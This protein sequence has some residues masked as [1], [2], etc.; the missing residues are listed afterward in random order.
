MNPPTLPSV[1]LP[2][3][4]GATPLPQMG[5]IRVQGEDAAKF[6]H[7][8]LTQDFAL[9]GLSEARLAAFCSAKGRML[10]SF[11]GFKLA[12]DDLLLVCSRDL[13]PATLKRLSMFVL[14]AKA[15]L[16]D[17]SAE[18]QVWGLSG[19]AAPAGA[20]PWSKSG[21]PGAA[22]TI[23]LYPSQG[24][25]RALWVAPAG[26]PPPAGDALPEAHWAWLDVM[27]GVATLTQPIA[28]AFV[29]QMLNYESVGGVNFKKGCYPGQEVVARSQFR[30]TLKRRAFL[31]QADEPLTVGQDVFH[32]S[33]AE[34]PCG[35]VAAA[36][37]N[38]AGG[39]SA[40]V[41]MQTSAVAGGSLHAGSATGP[42]LHL[43]P[44]PYP[45]LEDV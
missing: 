34:Q 45:L 20:K 32:S 14:R 29:P 15:R 31:V 33:D 38:P 41:S 23:A 30:G 18:F 9:L 11:V 22:Q 28:E 1:P 6:L 16:S 8:Q 27:A 3:L 5:I 17:A 37:A 43:L 12:H 10:A 26:H 21:E 19:S 44:L 39:W 24:L 42:E 13:V 25:P 36:A 40:T 4:H 2:A 35:T 7:G